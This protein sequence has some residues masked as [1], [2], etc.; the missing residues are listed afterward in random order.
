MPRPKTDYIRYVCNLTIKQYEVLKE[1]SDK[2][3]I[4]IAHQVRTAV[5]EYQK[6]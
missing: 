5:N 6:N 4:P 1:K 3:G 2:E